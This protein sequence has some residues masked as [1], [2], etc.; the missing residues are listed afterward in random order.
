MNSPSLAS[1][2]LYSVGTEQ[3]NER[4][5]ITFRNCCSS[6][7]FSDDSK[8]FAY[9]EWLKVPYEACLIVLDLETLKK[10]K[11]SKRIFNVAEL[12]DFS[13][14]TVTLIDDPILSKAT[15]RISMKDMIPIM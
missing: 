4:L 9:F 1:F 15:E 14:E 5:L 13:N 3:N 10:R 12:N 11:Y 8:Y 7:L 2:D 6:I